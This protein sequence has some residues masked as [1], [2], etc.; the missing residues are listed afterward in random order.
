MDLEASFPAIR[1]TIRDAEMSEDEKEKLRAQLADL[2]H[3]VAFLRTG[4][5]IHNVHF[6]SVLTRTVTEKLRSLCQTLNIDAPE[7]TLP[8]KFEEY[9]E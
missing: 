3:D 1:D 2:E 4:N 6:S 9:P 7:V 8:E 5:G